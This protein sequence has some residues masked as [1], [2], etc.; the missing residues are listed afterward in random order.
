MNSTDE[1]RFSD[2][3]MDVISVDGPRVM[4]DGRAAEDEMP[5]HPRIYLALSGREPAVCPYCGRRFQQA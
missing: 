2:P 3:A 4:C 5:Q 1:E